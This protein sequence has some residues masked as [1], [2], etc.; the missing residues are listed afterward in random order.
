MG[1]GLET[2]D[3]YV[4]ASGASTAAW[5]ETGTPDFV[6]NTPAAYKV[7]SYTFGADPENESLNALTVTFEDAPEPSTYALMLGGLALLGVWNARRR[8]A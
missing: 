6:F 1:G 2:G 3:P 8:M 5:T 4:L 7:S